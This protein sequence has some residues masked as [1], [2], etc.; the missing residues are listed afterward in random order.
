MIIG[1]SF[2]WL[3]LPKTGGTSCARLFRSLGIE[4]LTVDDDESDRKHDSLDMRT[5]IKE[6]SPGNKQVFITSRRLPAWLLSDWHHKRVFMGLDLPF[7]P[8]KSGLFYS[9]RLGGVWVS[10]DFWLSY[11]RVTPEMKAVRLEYLE[12]DANRLIHPLLPEGTPTLSFEHKNSNNYSR[13]LGDYLTRR[14]LSRIY[15]N[16]PSWKE[17]E[18]EVYGSQVSVGIVN[19]FRRLLQTG[20]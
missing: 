7:D 3:H 17:W 13:C 4:S 20:P 1:D 10:A 5:K 11:F 12:E 19:S 6:F 16:N 18:I 9:L 14:D 15:S 2:V 8:V